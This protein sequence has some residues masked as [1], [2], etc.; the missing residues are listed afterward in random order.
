MCQEV[1]TIMTNLFRLNKNYILRYLL[2]I[3]V[4]LGDEML[5]RK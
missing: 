1:M 5:E 3:N 2:C 4:L